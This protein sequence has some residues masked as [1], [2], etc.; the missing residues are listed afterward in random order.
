MKKVMMLVA[1]L[2]GTTAMVN[3]QTA[4]AKTTP[5]KEAKQ[6]VAKKETKVS[7]AKTTPIK[8]EATKSKK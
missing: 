7:L 6:A 1:V 4:Q 8:V 3:A 5:V 2:L